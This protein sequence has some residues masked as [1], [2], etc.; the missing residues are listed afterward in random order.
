MVP[1]TA[2]LVTSC[3]I[4]NKKK[5]RVMQFVGLDE[6]T[7]KEMVQ[8]NGCFNQDQAQVF[9]NRKSFYYF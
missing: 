8:S 2:H 9:K 1:K 4:K 6:D 7:M 3:T 5:N